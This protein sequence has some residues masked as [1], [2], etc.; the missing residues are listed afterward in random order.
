MYPSNPT[1]QIY[2]LHHMYILHS[3]PIPR[4]P[5]NLRKVPL[6]ITQRTNTPRLQPPLNTIQ[7]KHMR[8]IPKGNAQSIIVRGAGIGLVFDGWFVEGIATDGAGFG[9]GI[10]GP[11]GDGVPFFDLE[12][13]GW[14]GFFGGFLLV[15]RGGSGSGGWW[16]G[17]VGGGSS[18]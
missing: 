10:P 5:L 2:T 4:N 16:F 18:G 9:A 12:A 14:E 7:M 15:G 8:T 6:R 13:G 3:H 17:I 1:H 11:H